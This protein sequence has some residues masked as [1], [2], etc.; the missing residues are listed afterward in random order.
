MADVTQ[1]RWDAFLQRLD[2]ELQLSAKILDGDH[3]SKCI[4]PDTSLIDARTGE[5]VLFI[6]LYAPRLVKKS[7]LCV[8]VAYFAL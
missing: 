7:N 8:G 3:Q 6:S 5:Y 4:S 2:D 1:V